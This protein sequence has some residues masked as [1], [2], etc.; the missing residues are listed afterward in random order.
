MTDQNRST[1]LGIDIGGANIKVSDGRHFHCHRPFALWQ[2][3]ENL[4]RELRQLLLQAPHHARVAVTM[5]GELT[6]CFVNKREGVEFI[7]DAVTQ[8]TTTPSV[9]Y[10]V[11][12]RFVDPGQARQAYQLA[13][14]SNWH[15][16]ASWVAR[17]MAAGE[18]GLL[19]D[20]GSTTTDVIP[21]HQGRVRT[22]GKDDFGRLIHGELVYTGV[23]RS[24]L[25]G[26]VLQLQHRGQTCPVMN[27]MFATALDAHIVL[28]H[29]P[30]DQNEYYAADGGGTS[31]SACMARMARLIGK[32]NL[33]FN[34]ADAREMAQQ[35]FAKQV[36]MISDALQTVLARQP[37]GAQ[38]WIVSGQGEF[39][40]EAACRQLESSSRKFRITRLS[41]C[42][43][44]SASDCATAFS[45]AQLAERP[46]HPDSAETRMTQ[47]RFIREG[48]L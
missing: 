17:D 15:A 7:L 38:R 20:T 4:A 18:T 19:V 13:A 47:N 41:E 1:V 2:Q 29:L 27:E 6:D 48:D 37:Q 34:E 31:R 14:A 40:A 10:L 5:T 39:L 26:I 23:L 12:G 32:D 43:D 36:D 25:S 35:V 11:D 22:L 8:A 30:A 44:A 42:L 28:G 21:F 3:P 46:L 24:S 16:L 9:V 45:I 33:T